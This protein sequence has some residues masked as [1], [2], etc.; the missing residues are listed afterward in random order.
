M[1]SG[2]RPVSL[3]AAS[4][5]TH[6]RAA[7]VI[8]IDESG[9]TNDG[10]FVITAVQCPRNCGE[11]L[12]ELLI[13][14][15]L[16]PWKSKSSSTPTNLNGDRLTQQVERLIGRINDEPVSWDAAAC[17]GNCDIDRRAM[18][19]CILSTKC[20]IN[21]DRGYEGDAVL[22]HDGEC[23]E[24]GN[25][26][27]K[28]RRAARSQFDGFDIRETPVYVTALR[29]GDR[30][31]PEI[32]AADYISGLI[33]SKIKNHGSIDSINFPVRRVDKSWSTPGDITP[34]TKYQIR[35]RD[36]RR[37]PKRED[38][39]AAWVE[40]R[41]PPTDDAWGDQPL[42]SITGRLNSDTVQEYIL[43]EI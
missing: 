17:W 4:S 15:G 35:S 32:T 24:F 21:W 1:P 14:L 22:I 36:R 10:A 8:G 5:D 42:E 18:T 31:Y 34:E 43:N 30:I 13:D 27:V 9:N 33:K 19:A 26:Y 7:H 40:G 20:L 16:E 38:R 3:S 12:A 23:S 6:Q 29:S 2:L 25:E 11:R 28:L 37:Q 39:V 41:R